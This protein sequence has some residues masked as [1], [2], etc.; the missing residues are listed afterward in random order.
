M[1]HN[2]AIET[3][4]SFKDVA[5]VIEDASKLDWELIS[6]CAL[7]PKNEH[8]PGTVFLFFQ[9]PGDY[10]PNQQEGTNV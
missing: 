8:N 3:Y 7:S 9:V 1:P 6:T 10:K 2:R 5:Q 4:G